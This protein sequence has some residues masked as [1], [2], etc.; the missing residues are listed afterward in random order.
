MSESEVTRYF[1]PL[2]ANEM[3]PSVVARLEELTD[4]VR[5]A[6]EVAGML[7]EDSPPQEEKTVRDKLM[8]LQTGVE[9]VLEGVHALGVHVKSVEPGL[10]DFRALRNGQEVFLC[11][12][13]GEARINWW[14]PIHTGYVGRQRVDIDDPGIWEWC[15]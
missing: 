2:E 8:E 14:H 7:R 15:N 4:F 11:W 3:L 1:T 12:R 10:L 13:E 5:E 9:A 6:R